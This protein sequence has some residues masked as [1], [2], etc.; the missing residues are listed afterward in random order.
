M[1]KNSRLTFLLGFALLLVGTSCDY[2]PDYDALS[3]FP[4]NG[5]QLN[6]REIDLVE[7]RSGDADEESAQTLETVRA[8]KDLN[9]PIKI[10]E[11]VTAIPLRADRASSTSEGRFNLLP[12]TWT[13]LIDDPYLVFDE[14]NSEK[15]RSPFTAVGVAIGDLDG[16]GLPDLFIVNQF[17]GGRL[18]RNL[19]DMK[20]VDVTESVGIKIDDMWGTSANLVDINNDGLL[21][22]YLCGYNSRNR[23][24]VNRGRKFAE[25]A[26]RY[27]LD[28]KGA[29]VG[30]SFA[31]VDRDGDLDVYLLTNR[32]PPAKEE[33]KLPIDQ[34]PGKAPRIQEQFREQHHILPFVDGSYLPVKSGQ[35]DYL[36]RNDGYE[37][38]DITVP[39]GIGK[40]PYQGMAAVWCDM[41]EDGWPDLYVTNDHK[42]ADQYFENQGLDDDGQI[43]FLDVTENVLN[44]MTWFAR[45]VE[46]ADLNSDGHADLLTAG[47]SG[48]NPAA[49]ISNEGV[50]Y[51]VKPETWFLRKPVPSRRLGNC[52]QLG[53]GNNSFID[54]AHVA[55][56]AATD[57]TWSMRAADLDNDGREDV[58]C[59]N[60]NS[61]AFMDNDLN[62]M[63]RDTFESRDS[64][65]KTQF[66]IDK[67]RDAA[68]NLVFRNLGNLN[69]ADVAET[70]GLG[71]VDV[72]QVAALADL[73][74]DGDLDL[75]TTGYQEKIKLYRNDVNSRSTVSFRLK[76][77]QT[78]S[79]GVGARIKLTGNDGATQTRFVMNCRGF[80]ASEEPVAHFGLGDG[81][82][83]SK[84]EITWPT[85]AVQT[86]RELEPNRR[87][88]VQESKSA[89]L[90]GKR[91]QL[92]LSRQLFDKEDPLF[93]EPI[94]Q[95]EFDDFEREPSKLLMHSQLGSGMAWAD[96]DRD[97]DY[98]LFVGGSAYEPGRLFINSG[99]RMRFEQVSQDCFEQDSKSEDMG[100]VFFDVD[101]DGDDDLYVVSGG[102][103]FKSNAKELSDRVYLNDGTGNFSKAE[104]AIPD[105]RA[106]GSTVSVADFDGDKKLDLFVG[107]RIQ[108]GEYPRTSSSYLLRNVGGKLVDVTEQAAR[109]LTT[110]G[111]VTSSIWS[112]ING[113]GSVD[114]LVTT[115]LGPVHCYLNSDG[116][117]KEVTNDV[118]L[119]SYLGMFNSIAGGDVDNDGDI[120]FVVGNLG[121]HSSVSATR[122]N[123]R[124]YYLSNFGGYSTSTLL[125]TYRQD[126]EEFLAMSLDAISDLLPELSDKYGS[127]E[128]FAKVKL[129]DAIAS[130]ELNSALKRE[131][132]FLESC[133]L[134]N[135]S[136]VGN[137]S[138]TVKPLPGL[139]QNSPIYGTQLCDVNGDGNLDLYVI[140]NN[141]LTNPRVERFNDG[142]SLL[143]L[144]E[145]DGSF[146]PVATDSGLFISD[147]GRALTVC[148][149][150]QDGKADFVAGTSS[151]GIHSFTNRSRHS[152]FAIDLNKLKNRGDN[153]GA[154]VLIKFANQRR[155]LHEIRSN[156]GYLSQSPPIVFTGVDSENDIDSIEIEFPDG[157]KVSGTIKDLF[158]K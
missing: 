36:Y 120:D 35:Y 153:I 127:N 56:M 15:L 25:Q 123:P 137:P 67:K 12:E 110:L 152:P 20:F 80:Q 146:E 74:V 65:Q 89:Q 51:G 84:V 130:G 11:L 103:E 158:N 14:K 48:N 101:Q 66:W 18:Y 132:N 61:R 81:T 114:L 58:F 23:L 82:G 150:N 144:G 111:M 117:L 57:W 93:G 6:I 148:D 140:Q 21:D 73:D 131:L 33:G 124:A 99:R 104:N 22:I 157:S 128:E 8:T 96:V 143:M 34:K 28:F 68:R 113:D 109:E 27:R 129:S 47:N 60:G 106:S 3:A 38:V 69:F 78:N 55:G 5:K 115:E 62:R 16:D 126:G 50:L 63:L 70:W 108:P 76:G 2:Q 145:G 154:R 116:V 71:T 54:I 52:V 44:K 9:P 94:E 53:F 142:V 141:F 24:Y 49:R 64:K 86:L 156:N 121:L 39:S 83:I 30:A 32:L 98:D 42:D 31:D 75:L 133:V 7:V 138:F 90:V 119:G 45:G 139:A 19:G 155:Q 88:E 95:L 41:N 29:C 100:A 112:D 97:G 91:I 147:E 135:N 13:G 79:F 37:F 40:N 149:L 105:F 107:G 10:S 125:E 151:A 77:L 102:V 136:T 85:G 134:I 43:G 17:R 26:N 1:P 122:E 46:I 118:G 92:D 87:Y 72:S 4:N 59:A